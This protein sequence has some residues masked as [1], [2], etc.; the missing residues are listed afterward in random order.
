[1]FFLDA[2]GKN[3]QEVSWFFW[4]TI[5]EVIVE[6]RKNKN[7]NNSIAKINVSTA[8][9]YGVLSQKAKRLWSWMKINWILKL[10]PFKKKTYDE[11]FKFTT[12]TL[13]K[14]D[15]LLLCLIC[16]VPNQILIGKIYSLD[17]DGIGWWGIK[18]KSEPQT[19]LALALA[20]PG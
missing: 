12:F 13:L 19:E 7:I 6:T 3:M 2:A 15:G 4:N 18:G 16:Q 8:E 10:R 5:I 20:G 1:M 14:L 17:S 11:L 9:S